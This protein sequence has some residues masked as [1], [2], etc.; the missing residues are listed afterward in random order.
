MNFHLN[1]GLDNNLSK[2]EGANYRVLGL[3]RIMD[4]FLN[5]ITR[6]PGSWT[7]Q[8]GWAVLCTGPPWAWR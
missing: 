6:A 8:P 4:L 5:G 7:H 2:V 1:S 3:N